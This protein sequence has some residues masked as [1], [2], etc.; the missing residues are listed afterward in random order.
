M[1]VIS[2]NPI[3]DTELRPLWSVVIP[4]YNCAKFLKKTLQSVLAQ[5]MGNEKMEIWVVDDGSMDNP[6]QVIIDL[7]TDRI[8]FYKQPQNVG[9]LNNFSTC[10]NLAKGK[11]I[12]LLHGDD[13]VHDGFYESL[14]HSLMS[15]DTVG[16]AFT[17]YNVVDEANKLI[18]RSELLADKAGVIENFLSVITSKQV[19]QTPSIVVKREVYEKLGAFNKELTWVEDWE[20]WIR[21]SCHYNFYY[22]PKILASYRVHN[23]SNTEDSVKTGRFITDVLKCIRVYSSYLKNTPEEKKNIINAA[24]LHYINFAIQQSRARLSTLILLKAF[25]L[26]FNLS[27]SL[28]ILKQI[29]KVL[30]RSSKNNLKIFLGGVRKDFISWVKVESR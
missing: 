8:G 5:D 19:I 12:H 14:E 22:E 7:K 15:D 4:T 27:S 26:C 20:M 2:V 24:K 16:A 9:Q 25:K 13:F 29:P 3:N 23:N 1:S 21:I 11:I 18:V 28:K 17:G 6:E 10:L 30:I